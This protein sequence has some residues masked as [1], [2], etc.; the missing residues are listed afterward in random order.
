VVYYGSALVLIAAV[1]WLAH[2][3][4]GVRFDFNLRGRFQ[5]WDVLIILGFVL[6]TVGGLA[7]YM[8]FFSRT[9]HAMEIFGTRHG[10]TPVLEYW[11]AG[12]LFAVLNA[13]IE[14][15]WFRG[16]LMGALKPLLPMGRLIAVQAVAFGLIHWF[17]TPQGLLGVV[18]AGAWGAL[19]GWWVYVRGSLWPAVLIHFLAD[20]LIFAYTN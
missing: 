19:L 15:F 5:A 7:G 17:G 12:V 3:F 9:H 8:F 16:L 14:E 4:P 10:A 18:L 1:Y 2:R 11:A 13:L 6:L 20:M